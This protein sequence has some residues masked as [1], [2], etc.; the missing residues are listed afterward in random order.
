MMATPPP[1]QMAAMQQQ[2]AVEAQKRGYAANQRISTFFDHP[3]ANLTD[4]YVAASLSAVAA[5][6]DRSRCPESWDER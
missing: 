3:D 1:A 2:I 4:K 6:A 5:S